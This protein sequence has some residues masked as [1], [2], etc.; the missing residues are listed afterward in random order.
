MTAARPVLPRQQAIVL[1]VIRNNV[2][3]FGY[4]PSVRE[5]AEDIG[6]V[7]TSTVAHHLRA[8]EY[9]GYIRRVHGQA[10]AIEVIEE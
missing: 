10:R 8:L 2:T 4:P 7:S 3:L 1:E 6:G 5:I 9:K